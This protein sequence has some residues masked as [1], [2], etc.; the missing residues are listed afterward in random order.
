MIYLKNKRLLVEIAEPAK[1]YK[2]TRFDWTGFITQVTLDGQYTFCGVESIDPLIGCGGRGF[3]NEFG[4]D[5]PIGYDDAKVGEL[6]PKLGVGLLKK[7]EEK[8]YLFHKDYDVMPFPMTISNSD[9]CIKYKLEA[10]PCRGYEVIQEKTITL[11]DNSIKI[12]YKL[13]NVG[14]KDI[15]TN[16]YCHNFVE[17]NENSIGQEYVLQAPYDIKLEKSELTNELTVIDKEISWLKTP[18]NVFYFMQKAKGIE[19]YKYWEITHKPSGRSVREYVDFSP[20]KFALWG[21][22]HVVSPEMFIDIQIK[23]GETKTWNRTYEFR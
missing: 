21:M 15:I 12:D 18:A 13:K 22:N 14:T 8:E 9:T 10:L 5:M 2:R 17:I 20:T 4:I 23:P 6:F 3:C 1:H 19:E 7:T 11:Q 16:E